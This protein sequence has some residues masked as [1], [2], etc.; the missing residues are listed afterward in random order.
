VR[1]LTGARSLTTAQ[2]AAL[3]N[4]DGPVG[5][6]PLAAALKALATARAT[7]DNLRLKEALNDVAAA[8]VRWR[9]RL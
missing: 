2:I 9:E 3:R 7:N 1:E 5:P 8:A 6:G 4:G